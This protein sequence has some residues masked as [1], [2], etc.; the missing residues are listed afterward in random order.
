MW[1]N[2]N[3][4]RSLIW[5]VLCQDSHSS[6]SSSKSCTRAFRW[7]THLLRS[8]WGRIA[9][10]AGCNEMQLLPR[11]LHFPLL[12]SHSCM[13]ARQEYTPLHW[14][15]ERYSH[16]IQGAGT[17]PCSISISHLQLRGGGS[18]CPCPQT[19]HLLAHELCV[20]KTRST[21]SLQREEGGMCRHSWSP[22]VFLSSN[23]SRNHRAGI[24][25]W[26]FLP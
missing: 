18:I 16:P 15:T 12:I 6:C 1:V 11:A 13:P 14:P 5:E 7:T 25:D 22:Q 2:G 9:L 21:L 19:S 24:F 3:A 26:K 8:Y 23:N 10:N 20:V 4:R 17:L